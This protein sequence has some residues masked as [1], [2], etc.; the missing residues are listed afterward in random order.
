MDLDDV[1][2]ER[3]TVWKTS[4]FDEAIEKAEVDAVEYPDAVTAR[5]IGLAQG[6]RMFDDLSDGGEVFSLMRTS[7]LSDGDYIASFFATGSEFE[8]PS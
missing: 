5:Y 2:E 8:A 6:F 1:F 4:S 7:P 3:I